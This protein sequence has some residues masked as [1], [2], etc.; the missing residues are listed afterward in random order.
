MK[1]NILF[2][3]ILSF[4]VGAV[5]YGVTKTIQV[6][7]AGDMLDSVYY[8]EIYIKN[9]ATSTGITAQNSYVHVGSNTMEVQSGFLN[10]M[11]QSGGTT[12]ITYDGMYRA[13]AAVS[14]NGGNG[15]EYHFTLMIN[16]VDQIDC[17]MPRKMAAGGDVGA[18]AISCLLNC[19]AGDGVALAVENVTDGTDVTI[20]D[21]NLTLEYIGEKQ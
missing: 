21:Y 10:G 15:K 5:A 18:M 9:N 4:F 8:G 16:N 12:T 20:N 14:A 6:G 1:K 11:T 17:H 3:I 7:P 13:V 2:T 19:T